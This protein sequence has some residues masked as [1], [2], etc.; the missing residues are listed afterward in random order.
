M[1]F[2]PPSFAGT[3]G[4]EHF[5]AG[6]IAEDHY[7]PIAIVGIGCRFPGDATD[8]EKFWD[9]ISQGKSALTTIP[10]DRWNGEAFYH[11]QAERNGTVSS[12]EE[13]STFVGS[14]HRRIFSDQYSRGAFFKR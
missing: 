1:P 13:K 4:A 6:V 14:T 7:Q 2:L 12:I 11:P 3:P 9:L 5:R 8:P 10:T